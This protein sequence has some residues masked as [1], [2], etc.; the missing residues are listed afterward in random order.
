[1]MLRVIMV[2]FLLFPLLRF[3]K[4]VSI[5]QPQKRWIRNEYKL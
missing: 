4:T 3:P 5:S 2:M 1:M